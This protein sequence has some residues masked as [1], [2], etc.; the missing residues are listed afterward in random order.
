[1]KPLKENQW[2]TMIKNN[3]MLK[4]YY[5]KYKSIIEKV[6]R[7]SESDKIGFSTILFLDEYYRRPSQKIGNILRGIMDGKIGS[8]KIPNDVYVIY[9][10]NISDSTGDVEA[11][12]EHEEFIQVDFDDVK[13]EE[14]AQ[15][16]A[17]KFTPV[18]VQTGEEDVNK[19][20]E[21]EID[22]EIYNAF[23]EALPEEL[24]G[25]PEQGLRMSPRRTEQTLLFIDSSLSKNPPK[26]VEEVRAILTYVKNLYTDY[27]TNETNPEY[28][29][30]KKVILD[31]VRKNTDI[32]VGEDLP[33][34]PVVEWR[35]QFEIFVKTKE[36]LG[37]NMAI[38]PV[39]SSVPGQGK[40][41][42]IKSYAK[43][44][45]QGLIYINAQEIRPDDVIGIPIPNRKEK[46]I[47][48]AFSQPPLLEKIMKEYNELIEIYKEEGRRYNVILFIDEFSRTDPKVFNAIRMMM[49]EHK[50]T[51]EYSLPEDMLVVCA[52][53]PNGE[54]TTEISEHMKDVINVIPSGLSWKD[55]MSYLISQT[56][57]LYEDEFKI[58]PVL[59]NYLSSIATDFA[60]QYSADGE[61]IPPEMQNYYWEVLDNVIIYMSPRVITS[62]YNTVIYSVPTDIQMEIGET[63]PNFEN[64]DKA[65]IQKITDI[66]VDSWKRTIPIGFQNQI[67]DK[68]NLEKSDWN[69]V[70]KKL[71]SRVDDFIDEIIQ[72]FAIIKSKVSQLFSAMEIYQNVGTEKFL[73]FNEDE[74]LLA[75]YVQYLKNVEGVQSVIADMSNVW[76]ALYSNKEIGVEDLENV[77]N[78][79][80]LLIALMPTYE[81][82]FSKGDIKLLKMTL[83]K[84]INALMNI[85]QY[86]FEK[87]CD[88]ITQIGIFLDKHEDFYNDIMETIYVE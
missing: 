10:S 41:S 19:E 83:F 43:N 87:D 14:F 56:E 13:K 69:K 32:K 47:E 1:M 28:N 3:P 80:K 63:P 45:N 73:K 78:F 8:D 70:K 81:E 35:K 39:L 79:Y 59:R 50:I 82:I 68:N 22:P 74:L 5:E 33:E 75:S 12:M 66:I 55:L 25:E 72:S 42:I 11:Q 36:T 71:I 31:Y 15:Y 2:Q 51:S 67:R 34:L 40:T 21:Y 60:S 6:R 62:T 65:K 27:T 46:N 18:D 16:I 86:D 84:S 52:M 77:Y 48:T 76:Q 64:L 49:L 37:E 20:I 85:E 24:G 9:A 54:G 23:S 29:K 17:N 58:A 53:N 38:T 44:N 26:N 57:T 7:N 30:I 88:I 61:L 4:M